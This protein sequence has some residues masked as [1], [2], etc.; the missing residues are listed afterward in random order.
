MDTG[1]GVPSLAEADNPVTDN[2]LT[3]TRAAEPTASRDSARFFTE[4]MQHLAVWQG[5]TLREHAFGPNLHGS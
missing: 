3:G 1:D 4:K 2:P 5:G